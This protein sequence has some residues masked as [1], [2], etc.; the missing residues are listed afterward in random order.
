MQTLTP[1]IRLA[2]W[3][4]QHHPQIFNALAQQAKAQGFSG[5]GDDTVST[6]I[7]TSFTYDSS[8]DTFDPGS[9]SLVDS[10]SFSPAAPEL[11]QFQL[12]PSTFS[13]PS[14]DSSSLSMPNFQ[15]DTGGSSGVGASTSSVGSFLSSGSGISALTSLAR[16]IFGS[17]SAQGATIATQA[18]LVSAGQNP[19]PIAYGVN[20]AGQVVPIYTGS[21][22]PA[23]IAATGTPALTTAGVAGLSLSTSALA[24]LIPSS[25]MPWVIGGGILW[26]L[27]SVSKRRR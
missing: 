14:F 16:A 25:I 12:D 21:T 23:A 26:L 3:L 7:G 27:A 10:S 11:T 1:A 6:D 5:L 8:N 15:V 20:A 19:A 24:S 2:S 18:K 13:T 22:V 17:S 9:S 4:L